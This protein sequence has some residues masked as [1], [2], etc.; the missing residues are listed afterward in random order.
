LIALGSGGVSGL[1]LGDSRQKFFYVYG[2]H[3]DGIFAVLGEELGLIGALGVLLLFALLIYR[4]FRVV[5]NSRDEFGALLA[6]GIV[7][8]IAYQALINVG[9]VSRAIPM[10]GIPMPF[11]S[12]GGS[13]LAALL[14]AIGI[15]LSVSRGASEPGS[16]DVDRQERRP[17]K[18]TGAR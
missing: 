5:L 7:C 10:T 12:Y 13:A 9:G 18:R 16:A 2:S 6:T 3:T 4:G 14:A 15:L 1:G 17:A 11:L 8:W